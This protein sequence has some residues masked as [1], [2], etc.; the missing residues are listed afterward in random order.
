MAYTIS[1]GTR[2]LIKQ[3]HFPSHCKIAG[4]DER[5]ERQIRFIIEIDKLK[6]IRRRTYVID[7][8]RHENT[9]EHSWHL[10][11]M[12]MVLAEYANKTIDVARAIRMTLIHDIVEIDAGDTFFYDTQA[13]LDKTERERA[14]ADRLFGLLPCD[15]AAEFRALWDEFEARETPEARFAVA[16][17][18]F[19]PQLHN[20]H[21]RGGSWKE[22]SITHDRV[23][24]RNGAT[25][26]EGAGRLWQWTQL[27]LDDAVEKG[28][29]S[30]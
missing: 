7:E 9:A 27:L 5:L 8:R 17:D 28:F 24:A 20:Y 15:Q 12:A 22:H 2:I 16:L 26:A 19:I 29:L 21:C 14:A 3:L 30:K 6:T 23:V 25:M 1:G 10:A 11:M 4:M 13:L 18:R